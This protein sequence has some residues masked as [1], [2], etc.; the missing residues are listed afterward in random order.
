MFDFL[1]VMARTGWYMCVS[2][3]W[4]VQNSWSLLAWIVLILSLFYLYKKFKKKKTA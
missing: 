2:V 1:P 4:F 3:D